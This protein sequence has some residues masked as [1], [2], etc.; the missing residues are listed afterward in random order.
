MSDNPLVSISIT[1]YNRGYFIRDAIK[2]IV[3]QTYTNWELIIV[4]DC[5]IDD[6]QNII[7]KCIKE[8]KIKDKTKV[9]VHSE[10]RGYGY[11]LNQAINESSGELITILDSDDS[12]AT[13]DAL[14]ISVDVHLKNPD[15][16]LTY[17]N[18]NECNEKL[19]KVKTVK[20]RQL[21][22]DETFLSSGRK[23]KISHLKVI[24]KNFYNMTEGINPDLKQTVDRDLILKIEEVGKLLF[25]DKIL[26]NYRFHNNNLSR[27][28]KKKGR[29]YLKF[30]N[31]M[32][33]QMY[34]DARK[35]R[36][37]K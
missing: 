35:R 4:D 3:K 25:I 28:I 27:T 21:R 9:F 31:K 26:L 10:N 14:R 13:D 30:V 34:E 11:S 17:S 20:T 8:F 7:K 16:A 24:K 1:C 37:I 36:K 22:K 2:S 33:N 29:N 19:E 18:Y 32:R 23:I 12:L 15:V 6:S 5:S